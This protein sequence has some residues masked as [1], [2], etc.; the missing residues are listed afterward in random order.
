MP[1]YW[2]WVRIWMIHL[3]KYTRGQP[4]RFPR[5]S[6]ADQRRERQLFV[7]IHKGLVLTLINNVPPLAIG[8][9]SKEKYLA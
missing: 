2:F 4:K 6:L 7:I 1:K 9:H 8:C 3:Q 5:V